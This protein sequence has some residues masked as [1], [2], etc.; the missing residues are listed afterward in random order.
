[1]R[2]CVCHARAEIQ[3]WAD[4]ICS[5]IA[6]GSAGVFFRNL[7]FI[8]FEILNEMKLVL[9]LRYVRYIYIA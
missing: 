9:T 3:P 4:C 6:I 8:N 2:S 1:M 7:D 5:R